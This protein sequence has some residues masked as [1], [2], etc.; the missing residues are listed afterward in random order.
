MTS[1]TQIV[2]II[3][4][5]EAVIAKRVMGALAG[6]DTGTPAGANT[7]LQLR[8]LWASLEPANANY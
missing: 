3:V 2:R 8:A 5:R 4:D 6:P 1:K 7:A